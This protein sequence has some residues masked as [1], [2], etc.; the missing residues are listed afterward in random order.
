[1]RAVEGKELE[2][3]KQIFGD[4]DLKAYL[5]K[6]DLFL[7]TQ[8]LDGSY[9][10]SIRHFRAADLL[11][12]EGFEVSSKLYFLAVRAYKPHEWEYLQTRKSRD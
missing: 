11:E 7:V 2:T 1:M 12:S 4:H 3:L 10:D 8:N 9:T 6:T 5:D